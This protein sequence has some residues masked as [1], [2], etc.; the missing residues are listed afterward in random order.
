MALGNCEQRISESWT[1]IRRAEFFGKMRRISFRH[2]SFFGEMRFH[3]NVKALVRKQKA[4]IKQVTHNFCEQDANT[5]QET[6][7][8]LQ[9]HPG[10]V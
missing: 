4:T 1:S 3:P 2:T 9:G 6:Q 5:Q 7:K 8:G 10:L